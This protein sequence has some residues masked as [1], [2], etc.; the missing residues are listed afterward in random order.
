MI[1]TLIDFHIHLFPL[2]LYRAIWK[3]FDK[4][5]WHVRYRYTAEQTLAYLKRAGVKR[6][7]SLNY[8]HKPGMARS[9]NHW[10]YDFASRNPMVIPFGTVHPGDKD[11]RVILK[12]AL[13][14]FGFKGVKLHCHVQAM[15]P[16]APK[17]LRIYDAVASHGG[18]ILIHSGVGPS[19]SGY[20]KTTVDVS[21]AKFMRAALKKFPQAKFVVPH[22]GANEIEPFFDLMEEFDNLWM[23]T[24]MLLAQ[25]FKIPIPWERI[26]KFYR[27]ILYGTDFPNIPYPY[28]RESRN[29]LSGP[30][31]VAMKESILGKNAARLL[32]IT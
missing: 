27:R 17:M 31:T 29:I 25:W 4:H 15:R 18:V 28:R 21:G 3:W 9:L 16:D 7:V 20:E 14:T 11:Y 12:E 8:A 1:P 19:L 2:P 26:R 10:T 13:G 23:D 32:K 6:A 22:L 5:G 30:L 24:T